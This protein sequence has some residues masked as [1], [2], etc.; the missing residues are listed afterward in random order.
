MTKSLSIESGARSK[1]AIDVSY[2]VDDENENDEEEEEEHE[3][4]N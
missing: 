4:E 1:G 2:G 3:E